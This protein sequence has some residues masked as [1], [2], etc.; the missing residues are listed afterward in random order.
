MPTDFGKLSAF[1]NPF[2]DADKDRCEM[3][4]ILVCHDFEWHFNN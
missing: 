1:A 2:S 3:W 4:N